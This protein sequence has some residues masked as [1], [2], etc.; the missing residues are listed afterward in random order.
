MDNDQRISSGISKSILQLIEDKDDNFS[1]IKGN[2]VVETI[3]GLEYYEVKGM[4]D[5]QSTYQRIVIKKGAQPC[6]LADYEGDAKLIGL[7][8]TAFTGGISTLTNADAR[9][10]IGQVKERTTGE[11]AVYAVLQQG[12]E[13][14]SIELQPAK[15][16]CRIVVG[17][18]PK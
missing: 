11:T 4:E 13:V 8:F 12:K 7:C 9:F 14:A 1:R 17:Q 16:M 5:M 3:D 18:M 15:V 2:L 6:Y 10:S